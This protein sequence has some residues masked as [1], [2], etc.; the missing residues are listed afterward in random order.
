MK[1]GEQ[2][3]VAFVG[4]VARQRQENGVNVKYYRNAFIIDGKTYHVSNADNIAGQAG[5]VMFVKAGEI[6]V[7]GGKVHQDAFTLL[8]AGTAS[9]ITSANEALAAYNA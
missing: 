3:K 2:Y 1:H 4:A 6:G 9:T 7:N 8:G 5:I